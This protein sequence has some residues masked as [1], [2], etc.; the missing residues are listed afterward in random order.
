V[1]AVQGILSLWGW[2]E[3][4]GWCPTTWGEHNPQ[5]QFESGRTQFVSRVYPTAAWIGGAH[6][7]CCCDQ[8]SSAVL[9][10]FMASS[11]G[12]VGRLFGKSC[13]EL[14]FIPVIL[15][16]GIIRDRVEGVDVPGL[17]SFSWRGYSRD[18]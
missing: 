12:D 11:D 7:G 4:P 2:W 16:S 9:F 10:H 6:G 15:A 1:S 13:D 3:L 5:P 14:G 8:F 18:A 17:C